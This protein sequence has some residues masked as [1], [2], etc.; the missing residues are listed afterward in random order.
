MS[1]CEKQNAISTWIINEV[2]EKVQDSRARNG[3]DYVGNF[4]WDSRRLSFTNSTL[5]LTTNHCSPDDQDS[6]NENKKFSHKLLKK[7]H[8]LQYVST[9]ICTVLRVVGRRGR[10]EKNRPRLHE[11]ISHCKNSSSHETTGTRNAI[12]RMQQKH[13]RSQPST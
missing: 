9:Q 3:S 1:L 4:G 7:K 11:Q 5:L 8:R 13:N 2:F 6:T 12:L 10:S